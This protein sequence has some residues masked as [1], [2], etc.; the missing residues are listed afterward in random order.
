[1]RK[2]RREPS[3]LGDLMARASQ[4]F[5]PEKKLNAV[6]WAETYRR[7]PTGN[8][9]PGKFQVSRTP[10][11]SEIMLAASDPTIHQITLVSA[12]QIGKSELMLNL[13][14]YRIMT[15]PGPVMYMLPTIE[16]LN[17]F[18]T[19]RIDPLIE[20]T[21]P[22]KRIFSP[23]KSRDSQNTRS[24]KKFAGGHLYIK[25][26][27]SASELRGRA[28]KTLF[29]DEI[30]AYKGSVGGEGDPVELAKPRMRTFSDRLLVAVSTP[31]VKNDSKIAEMYDEGTQERYYTEC[32]HCHQYNEMKFENLDFSPVQIERNGKINYKLNGDVTYCCPHCGTYSD[33]QTMKAQPSIWKAENPD[34]LQEGHRSFW[35]NAFT[36]PWLTWR[37][38]VLTFL[39]T[40]DDPQRFQVTKNTIFGELWE[41]KGTYNLD[42]NDIRQRR[43]DYGTNDDGTPVEVPDA[44][45][46]LTMA[47]DTQDTWL[48]YEIVGYGLHG[49]TYGIKHGK[50]L[51]RPD[52]EETQEKLKQ[53]ISTPRYFRNRESYLIPKITFIDSGGHY[54]TTIK[55]FCKRMLT[56][57]IAVYPIKGKG[58][59]IDFVSPPRGVPIDRKKKETVPLITIGVNAGK[60]RIM[61]ALS[62]N[63][64]DSALYCHFPSA[65]EAGYD[66][67]YFTGLLS[68][69]SEYNYKT[70]KQEWKQVEG[71]KR[72]EPLDI[73]NYNLAANELLGID[74]QQ[75]LNKRN[76]VV[77][78]KPKRKVQQ[79]KQ[80]VIKARI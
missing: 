23:K 35:L 8:A 63:Q 22:L 30:D 12:A 39:K 21:Q 80:R 18:S 7:L 64:S 65:P 49:Q 43:E 47:V 36:S 6:E 1:M 4:L 57:K 9:E 75:E 5:K 26:A 48:E 24:S 66:A 59:D 67:N 70:H 15:N 34:A 73:R 45:A 69:R 29:L 55:R 42:P 28:V 20:T 10:Y 72:N 3:S 79:K 32:P 58:G 76:G 53:V 51:G 78:P 68:E 14:G 11:I 13:M 25:S 62:V 31:T 38:A 33:E 41:N 52:D 17:D 44:V 27:Q 16:L 50:I 56:Q 37:E 77:E 19:E 46:Y 74:V 2:K 60:A 61:N 71:V 54:A 40:K